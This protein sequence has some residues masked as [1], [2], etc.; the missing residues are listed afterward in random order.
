M[1]ITVKDYPQLHMLCWNRSNN[2]LLD[3]DEA[4]ALY[5]RNWRFIDQEA[6]TARE[7][8]LINDLAKKHGG[9]LVAA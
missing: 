9:L 3:E 5:E 7:R 4:L 8:A 2:A 1:Q 6:V